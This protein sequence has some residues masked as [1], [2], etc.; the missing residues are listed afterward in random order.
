MLS[1]KASAYIAQRAIAS[2]KKHAS[3][4][5]SFATSYVSLESRNNS[6]RKVVRSLE[7]KQ[8]EQFGKL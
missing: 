5:R 2:L 1:M 3:E 8:T 7:Y 4:I 6:I